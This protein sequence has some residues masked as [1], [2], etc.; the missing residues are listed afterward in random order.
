[1]SVD[2]QNQTLA[3]LF[4]QQ[5]Q[6]IQDVKKDKQKLISIVLEKTTAEIRLTSLRRVL[7][8]LQVE[9][10]QDQTSTQDPNL[11][12][13]SLMPKIFDLPTD[14]LNDL[15]DSIK[16]TFEP[17]INQRK[18]MNDIAEVIRSKNLNNEA[19]IDLIS[20]LLI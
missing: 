11:S 4:E 13:S 18:L 3:Q 16:R 7:L 19:K 9:K 10:A 8:E 17:V 5:N 15:S 20:D 1:M 2:Q 14:Q 6:I 12:M